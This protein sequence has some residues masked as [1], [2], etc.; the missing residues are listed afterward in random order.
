MPGRTRKSLQNQWVKMMKQAAELGINMD[1][2][3][4]DAGAAKTPVKRTP[5]KAAWS[6]L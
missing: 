3:D 4:D 1:G 2:D 6:A 5:G